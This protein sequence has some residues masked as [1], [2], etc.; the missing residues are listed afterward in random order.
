[1]GGQQ[2]TY[3]PVLVSEYWVERK[4]ALRVELF[5]WCIMSA[6]GSSWVNSIE[7]EISIRYE[8]WHTASRKF[9]KLLCYS[10]LIS[11]YY[12]YTHQR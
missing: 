11:F 10:F 2:G 8:V 9:L 7:A 4:D 3:D 1:M 5:V 12:H 6:H